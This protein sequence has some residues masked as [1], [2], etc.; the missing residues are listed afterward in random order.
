MP[1]PQGPTRRER[2]ASAAGHV[3]IPE[4]RLA[5][6]ETATY[7]I[8]VGYEH[9]VKPGN[10]VGA[11]AN[12]A[13]LSGPQIGHV[14]IRGDHSYVGLPVGMPEA[15][16]R[17]LSK[18]RVAGQMLRMSMAASVPPKEL[19]KP[20]KR[21]PKHV[22]QRAPGSGAGVRPRPGKSEGRRPVRKG[23]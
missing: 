17:E 23:R 2:A 15:V 20:P 5:E 19:R 16:L 8:E 10:I 18:T 6:E 1:G 11:I 4:G 7:R 3:G 13:G 12:V 9:G 21:A 14:D 22:S